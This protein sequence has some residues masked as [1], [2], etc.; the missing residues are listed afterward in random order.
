MSAAP[1]FTSSTGPLIS[2]VLE[3]LRSNAEVQA[4]YGVPAR[5]YDADV[6]GATYPYAVLE[7]S[8][9]QVADGVSHRGLEHTLHFASY[10][11]HSGVEASK[12]LISVLRR[13]VEQMTL[14][15]V[16]QRIVL[17]LPTYCDVLRT[18][19]QNVLRGMLRVRLR[20]E[21]V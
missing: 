5:I 18:K 19:N 7:R 16:D 4:A 3:A 8:E 11:R 1:D 6:P 13:A 15:V 10:A 12:G 20:T 14:D 9:A 17:V 2:A 21:E